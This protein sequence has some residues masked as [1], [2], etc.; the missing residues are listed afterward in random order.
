MAIKPFCII[1]L[2]IYFVNN[3]AIAR[4]YGQLIVFIN[5]QSINLQVIVNTIP[6]G[7][8]ARVDVWL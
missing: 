6:V 5:F 8:Q 4:H 3:L 1:V 2:A 7:L